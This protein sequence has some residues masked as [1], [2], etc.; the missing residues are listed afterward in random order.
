MFFFSIA[1]DGWQFRWNNKFAA[2][3]SSIT[4]DDSCLHI[5]S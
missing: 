1:I 4:L 3:G 5:T 2:D